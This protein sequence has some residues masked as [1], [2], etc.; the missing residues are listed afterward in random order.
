MRLCIPSTVLGIA[1][2]GLLLMGS[3]GSAAA[4]S[5]KIVR[6]KDIEFQPAVTR[7][8]TGSAVTWR[9][10]DMHVS[11]NVTSRGPKRFKSSATKQEG[12]TYTVR[13]PKSGTYRYVCTIHAGMNGRVV[14]G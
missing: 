10:Q 2:A 12:A 14:V 4:G 8:G 13:F 6:V 5:N 9:F 1:G 11:H 3:A 7:I